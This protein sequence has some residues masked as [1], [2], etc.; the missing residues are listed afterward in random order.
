[1]ANEIIYKTVEENQA[2]IANVIDNTAE[3]INN[4]GERSGNFVSN[5]IKVAGIGIAVT[6]GVGFAVYKIAKA[7]C[8]KNKEAIDTRKVKMMAAR[9]NKLR[10]TVSPEIMNEYFVI[11]E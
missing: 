9:Y 4:A 10:E 5:G 11:E 7:I 1:M 8:E 2:D 6:A 3:A